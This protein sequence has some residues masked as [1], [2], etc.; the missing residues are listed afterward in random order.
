MRMVPMSSA[1]CR[2]GGTRLHAHDIVPPHHEKRSEVA[3]ERGHGGKP[4][5]LVLQHPLRCC[6][7]APGKEAV[8]GNEGNDKD[9]A[10]HKSHAHLPP[11]DDECQHDLQWQ[12]HNRMRATKEI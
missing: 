4:T 3:K 11:E 12:G 5:V 1:A 9:Q 7:D 2:R 8:D 6:G 10:R